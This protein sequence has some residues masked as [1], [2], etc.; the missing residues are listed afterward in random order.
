MLLFFMI[1][2]IKGI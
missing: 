1:A 2:G